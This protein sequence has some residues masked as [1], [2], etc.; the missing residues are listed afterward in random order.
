MQETRYRTNRRTVG[1]AAAGFAGGIIGF[2]LSEPMQYVT[3][4]REFGSG[5]TSVLVHVGLWFALVVLGIGGAVT[6]ADSLLNRDWAKARYLFL[7]AA[8]LLLIGGVIAGFIAQ[9][10]YQNMI[11]FDAAARAFE[12]CNQTGD[13]S[14]AAADAIYRP[15]RAVGWGVAGMLG[16][17]PI[18]LAAS[19]RRLAQ[20]GAIGGLLGGLVGGALF[21][22]IDNFIPFGPPGLPRVIGIVLIGT[23]IGVAFSL[24][25]AARTEVFLEVL[26]GDF[27]GTQFPLTDAKMIVGCAANAGVTLRG[28]RGIKEHHIEIHWDGSAAT[29]S[30]VR[31]SPA[32]EVDGASSASGPLPLG[33]TLRIGSTE[34]RLLGSRGR[35]QN[36]A[37]GTS[38]TS[39]S[40]PD[41]P[42]G[43]P[44][45]TTRD[46]PTDPRPTSHRRETP[47]TDQ[48]QPRQRPTIPTRPSEPS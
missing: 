39:P 2:A 9:L 44:T 46:A 28:D 18:G 32:I 8:P 19:S 26:N 31:N 41:A 12:R 47:S 30:T 33:A 15:G 11:D 7:R 36:P 21:D 17:I 34:L 13:V 43:R 6:T 38:S 29:F 1:T 23:L 3:E 20:N 42:L 16:G 22:S 14:C 37:G 25:T 35:S 48:Q 4:T 27:V 40:A 45:I 5:F 10:V 24:I